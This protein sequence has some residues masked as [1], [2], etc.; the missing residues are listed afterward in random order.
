M[1]IVCIHTRKGPWVLLPGDKRH[2]KYICVKCDKKVLKTH[3]G[4]DDN[5][6]KTKVTN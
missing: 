3:Q 6:G 2:T 5:F 4:L 1:I